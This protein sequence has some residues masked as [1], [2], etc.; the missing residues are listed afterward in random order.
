MEHQ[1]ISQRRRRFRSSVRVWGY[2]AVAAPAAPPDH[3]LLIAVGVVA[4]VGFGFLAGV[5][6]FGIGVLTG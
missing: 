1:R 2:G 5:T 6:R 3:L 4:G